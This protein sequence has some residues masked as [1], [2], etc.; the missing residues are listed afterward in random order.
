[1]GQTLGSGADAE[2]VT[3][4][5]KGTSTEAE[6]LTQ[7]RELTNQ[8]AGFRH[9]TQAQ[10]EANA[11]RA[12]SQQ[13]ELKKQLLDYAAQQAQLQ[14]QLVDNAARSDAQQA[15]LQEQLVENAARSDA[16]Q[17]ELKKQLLD[18]AAQ[19]AQ[20][21]KQLVDNAARSDAQQAQ[22]EKAQSQLK[23]AVT[24]MKKT[25]A[26]LEEVQERLRERELPDHL[27]NLRAKGW[28]LFYIAFRDSVVKVLDNPVYKA[29]VKGCGSFMELENLLSLRTDGSLTVAV[30]AAIEKSSFGHDNGAVPDFWKQWK[31]VEALNAGRNAVVH[32]SV[33]I[34]AEKLRTALAD[35]HAFPAAGP[36]K[37]MIQ[38][39]A[40]YC[41]SKSAQLDA[42]AA[43]LDREN[44][45]IS[46]RQRERRQQLR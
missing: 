13:A 39:L 29:A 31:V 22:L 14:K 18:Y 41:L 16:Q 44:L 43:D 24:Q 5:K 30:T 42:A 37:A 9:E 10:L 28:E 38:C 32:C 33:G 4:E 23:I 6:F 7:L 3:F 26:E 40:T 1:M 35:P 27:H 21:Q 45:A 2:Y 11:A 25:A 20:L 34:S 46:A 12:D 8:L 36:A 17:A 15:Q 19:Q